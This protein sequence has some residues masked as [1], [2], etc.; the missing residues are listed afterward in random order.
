MSTAFLS[1]LP[2]GGVG[3]LAV[4]V[5]DDA[6]SS[7]KAERDGENTTRDPVCGPDLGRWKEE[8]LRSTLC[9]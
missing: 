1:K 5:E 6:Q 7:G 3:K 2:R 8:I 4:L 9:R